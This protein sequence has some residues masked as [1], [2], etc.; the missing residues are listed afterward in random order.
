MSKNTAASAYE[1]IKQR[2]LSGDLQLGSPISES[3]IAQ[4][5]GISRSPIREAL[6]RME[7]EGLVNHY[8]GRGAFVTQITEQDVEE[9]F[10]LRLIIEL[11]ALKKAYNVIP[12]DT[13]KDIKQKITGLNSSSSAAQYYEAN[14]SLH[15]TIINYGVSN[16]LKNFYNMVASMIEVMT[17]ISAKDP[18]HFANSRIEH[19]NIIE[20]LLNR[21]RQGAE[22]E[23][24]RHIRGVK[25]KTAKVCMTY[26]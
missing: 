20:A 14:Q 18:N 1:Y 19:L 8:P 2:I 16:R 21:D 5:L 24:S 4:I 23:L 10:E 7:S 17:R 13:I 22:D 15:D 11:L 26:R 25:T 6:K 12:E 9:I 3:E